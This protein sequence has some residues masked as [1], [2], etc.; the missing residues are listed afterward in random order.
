MVENTKTEQGNKEAN[1]SFSRIIN[2]F[3]KGFK[4]FCDR[5]KNI[6]YPLEVKDIQF[7]NFK[8]TNYFR[9]ETGGLVSIRPCKE[10]KSY[11]GFMLGEIT[12]GANASFDTKED[13]VHIAPHRNVAILVPSLK[14]IVLGSESWWKKIE[15]EE[16]MEGISNEEIQ[17]V[18]YVKVLEGIL[19]KEEVVN[20]EK[21]D[22][23]K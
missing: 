3:A 18:W 9:C 1:E 21:K 15:S 14:R 12:I 20:N 19:K 11:I 16:D 17:N 13:A 10:E 22:E 8:P 23:Q 7:S 2:E 5:Y 6:E 4:E